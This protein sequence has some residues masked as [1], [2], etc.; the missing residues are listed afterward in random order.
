M[1]EYTVHVDSQPG[2]VQAWPRTAGGEGAIA[3]TVYAAHLSLRG[4]PCE[5]H[6]PD[7]RLLAR[8]K[9]GRRADLPPGG[10][11]RLADAKAAAE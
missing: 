6:R 3:A 8:Y 4:T 7:G 11:I 1:S 2:P 9:D 10:I 5:V